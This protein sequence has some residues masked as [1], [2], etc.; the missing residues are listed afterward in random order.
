LET[1]ILP[2]D[3][4]LP[5]AIDLRRRQRARA[6]VA[7]DPMESDPGDHRLLRP[8]LTA[9]GRAEGR[10]RPFEAL[11]GHDHSAVRL[12]ERLSA[13]PMRIAGRRN[14]TRPSEPAVARGAHVFE[15]VFG[16][17]VELRVAVAVEGARRA[18][19]T[20]GPVLVQVHLLAQW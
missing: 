20:D 6:Q 4:H 8:A 18:V 3:I 12:H 10:D 7:R 16:E 17:V 11:E 13:D 14:G 19:V 15:I 2:G 1:T 5:R 9:V